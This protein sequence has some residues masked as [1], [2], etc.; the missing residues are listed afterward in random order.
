MLFA[1]LAAFARTAP[2]A[3]FDADWPP[4]VFTTVEP[5]VPETSPLNVPVKLVALTA[6]M[7]VV[8]LVA[9]PDNEPEN[10]EAVIVPDVLKLPVELLFTT[11][12]FVEASVAEFAVFTPEIILAAD[13]PVAL[14]P[15]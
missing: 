3:M 7:A 15:T 12:P 9:L 13:T 8:A 10:I 2:A 5:C 14:P 1:L 4:T 11:V 6:L